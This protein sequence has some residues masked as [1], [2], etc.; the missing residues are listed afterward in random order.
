MKVLKSGTQEQTVRSV[1]WCIGKSQCTVSPHQDSAGRFVNILYGNSW[2][3]GE[4]LGFTWVKLEPASPVG[5]ASPLAVVHTE[6]LEDENNL[7]ALPLPI[8]GVV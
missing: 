7:C 2:G 5:K 1:D 3:T 8:Q 4:F 6:T